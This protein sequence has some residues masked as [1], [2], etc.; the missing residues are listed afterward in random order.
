[1]H[2]VIHVHGAIRV[3]YRVRTRYLDPDMG[4]IESE[5]QCIGGSGGVCALALSQLGARVHLSGNALGD[6]SH[7]RFLKKQLEA[8]GIIGEFSLQSGL[9]TPYA[10]LLR[11]DYGETQTLLSAR[12][13]HL[14]LPPLAGIEGEARVLD[15][16]GRAGNGSYAELLEELR[17]ALRLWLHATRPD[18][19][20]F[21]RAIQV[22]SW[23]AK[24]DA[25]FG[26]FSFEQGKEK[27]GSA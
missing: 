7:G 11:D 22:E 16:S 19:E 6:D 3:E 26:D 23:I 17:P 15:L 27:R 9:S 10:I 4:V 13:Q 18:D 25:S 24:Y 8:A 21:L 14:E 1:M 12:A 2:P 5:T 20:A